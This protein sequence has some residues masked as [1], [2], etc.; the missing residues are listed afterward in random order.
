[1]YTYSVQGNLQADIPKPSVTTA[2][3]ATTHLYPYR[4]HMM[5]PQLPK[6]ASPLVFPEP[7]PNTL[8]CAYH[9]SEGSHKAAEGASDNGRSAYRWIQWKLYGVREDWSSD[10]L[11]AAKT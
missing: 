3:K 1:M 2:N 10:R 8:W 9:H 4:V 11:L 7:V 6:A 5:V